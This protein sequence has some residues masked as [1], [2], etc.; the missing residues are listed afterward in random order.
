MGLVPVE[1]A[2][3]AEYNPQVRDYHENATV[4]RSGRGG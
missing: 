4:H 2:G 3:Y 1:G